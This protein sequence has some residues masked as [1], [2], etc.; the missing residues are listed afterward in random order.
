[1]GR[2]EDEAKRLSGGRDLNAFDMEAVLIV[3]GLTLRARDSRDAVEREGLIIDDGKGFPIEHPGLLVEKRASAE[4]RG[5]VKDR[6]DLFGARSH[7]EAREPN[8]KANKFGGFKVV[9]Q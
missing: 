3:A 1:M 6:P 5:W 9:G 4:I 7:G 8:P 2:I